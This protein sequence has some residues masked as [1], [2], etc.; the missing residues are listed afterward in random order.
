ML[1]FN[2]RL[3]FLSMLLKDC[4][5]FLSEISI[6]LLLISLLLTILCLSFIYF[7]DSQN[8]FSLV[9]FL[10]LLRS[11]IY[12]SLMIIC[13]LQIFLWFFFYLSLNE[14]RSSLLLSDVFFKTDA[15]YSYN[16]ILHKNTYFYFFFTKINFNVDL[17]GMLIQTV[18]LVIGFLSFTV[19][20]TRFF[21]KNIKYLSIFP[22]FT[23]VVML[24]TIV[25]NILLFLFF[26][27]YYFYHL[28][29]WYTI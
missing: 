18:G 20:D 8:F 1:I 29:C 9:N 19:L 16:Y 4:I 17:F 21:F 10:S 11:L 6:L 5:Y 13:V 27:S 22:F 28:S 23:V 3:P 25:N 2:F 7:F 15:V 24:F 26:T 14:A 12:F